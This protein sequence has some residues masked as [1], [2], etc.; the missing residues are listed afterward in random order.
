LIKIGTS[1]FSF[2]DW[3]G[4]VYPPGL[5]KSQWLIYYEKELGFNIL[6]VNFTYYS[7]ASPKS[8]E[9][10][11]RKTSQDFEFVVKAFKGMTHEIRDKGTKRIIDNREVFE[12]F[13][14][15]VDP[16]KKDKKLCCILMQ[17][18]YSFYPTPENRDYLKKAMDWLGELPMVV[19]FRNRAWI[20]PETYG[21]L[22][23]NQMGYCTVDE[24]KLKGLVPFDPRVTSEIGYFRFHGRNRNWFNAPTSLRYDYL[25]SNEELQD[26]V[27]PIK[28]ISSRTNKVLVF[29]N[30]CHAGSA[31]KNALMLIKMFEA[32]K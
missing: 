10:M 16:L 25:Y 1:G 2:E 4:T 11:S 21:F 24:P 15:S 5:N 13:L 32:K 19:E 23:E 28:E 20:R 31:V 27:L 7:L 9:G 6:E 18:P 12:K 26:F 30:N 29:F 17:F 8:F 22:S 3:K 14:F